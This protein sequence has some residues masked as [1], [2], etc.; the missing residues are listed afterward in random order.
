MKPALQLRLGQQ[1]NMTP[2]LQQAIK[3][4]QLSSQEL[5]TQLLEALETNPLLERE[6]L[7]LTSAAGADDNAG[8]R[9]TIDER[10]VEATATDE[11]GVDAEK[12]AFTTPDTQPDAGPDVDADTDN[13]LYEERYA[14]STTGT[15]RSSGDFSDR[16][17]DF[18]DSDQDTLAEHLLWQLNLSHALP[19][20]VAIGVAIIDAIGDDGYLTETVEA[21][22]MSLLPEWEVESDEV[23]AMRHRLQHFDP[24]GAASCSLQECLTIQLATL[25][26]DT[27]GLR[28]ASKIVDQGLDLL[29]KQDIVGLRR[30]LSLTDD[31]L[32]QGIEL[33][34][35]LEPRP[36]A[37]FSSTPTEYVTPDVV[38]EKRAGVWIARLPEDTMPQLRVNDFYA[39]M[40]GKASKEDSNY[41]RGQLQ[42]ARWLIKSLE[43]RNETLLKVA[44]AIVRYQSDF[45][46][47]GP[48]AMKPLVLREVADTIDMHESTV[49]RVTTRKYMVTPR[50]IFEFKYFFSSHV[51]TSDGGEM[52]ATAIQAMINRLVEGEPP[53]KP[54]SDSKLAQLLNDQGI[55]VARRTV[56]KYRE[57][58]NIPSS[59]RRKRLM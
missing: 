41:L 26:D 19:R 32:R 58:L 39:G 57:A 27:S 48:E 5:E 54:L 44:N 45:F 24:L 43:A 30:K 40:I 49:S 50:G 33:V 42:E 36:G 56:A 52:S 1:L 12:D 47:L 53:A 28:V 16:P 59:S 29:A 35:S 11:I 2:Q 21:I 14:A 3:L 34:R 51:G 31:Q 55:D 4:L 7:E 46:E 25:A 13:I 22:R 10:T 9:A 20:D 8:D 23:E 6:D 17:M 38:V 15:T 18:A 37:H